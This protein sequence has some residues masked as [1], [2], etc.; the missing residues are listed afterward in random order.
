MARV[1]TRELFRF[2]RSIFSHLASNPSKFNLSLPSSPFSSSSFEPSVNRYIFSLL[3]SCQSLIQITQ[4]HAHLITR[5]LFDSFWARKLLNSYYYFGDFDYTIWVF[6]YIDAPGRFCVNT[7]IKAYSLSS[8][9][10]RALVVYLEWLRNGFVPNSYTFVPVFGSCAKM[11][12]AE[13]GRTCH[14]QVVKYGVDSVLHVQ[15]SLIHMYCRCGELELARKVFDEMPERDLVSWNAIVDGNAR[16][17]DIEVARRL[18]DEMPERNVVS[19]NVM[20]GG[21]WKG[22][23][24]ECALKL[25]RKMV[26][27]GLRGNETTMVNMLAACGRSARLN[28]GR[29]VHGCL[30]RTFLEWNIF[31]NT[32]LIDMYCKCERVQV[33]RLV[34][35]STA[36]RNLVCWNAMILGHCIHG[37]PEDGFNLYREMV[38]RTKSRDGE[39]IHEKESSRPD[40]D[41]EGI[42]PDEVTFIGVLCACA[43]FGLVRE[44][45][46]Y[47]SQMINVFQVKPNFAHYWCMA[48]ALAS[49][50]LRQEAEGIIRNMPEVAVDLA[51]ESLAWASLLGSCRFQ[52]DAKLGEI[53]KSLI[54]KEPQ[55]IAYYRLLLN[56]YAVSGQWENVTQVNKMMKEMKLGRIP[57]CNLVDLNEIV[58]EL[59]VGRHYQVDL[60]DS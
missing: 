44:A 8:A 21:Y 54:E 22:G 10:V 11:G 51:P 28:E 24:P 57:G 37:N 17:G 32:A 43:R 41:R 4:L 25:F 46:D 45:R 13:S 6:V 31:L 53:A 27:M 42:I 34:F 52:G 60:V 49:V 7:V 23:K 26:G 36:Y 58:H 12:C 38:G 47:F 39:T 56:V 5:G 59:R 50:G 9:P 16:F 35:E 20:L 18:F 40:E 15:N 30:I 29:S 2:R 48:N 55:N 3:D 19:W 33:A 14:G 1:C